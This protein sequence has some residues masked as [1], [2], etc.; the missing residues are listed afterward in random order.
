MALSCRGFNDWNEL[1]AMRFDGYTTP[2][3]PKSPVVVP[4]TL[5]ADMKQMLV[6][7]RFA[8]I[9][10]LGMDGGA[11]IRAHRSVLFSRCPKLEQRLGEAAV[12]DGL[13]CISLSAPASAVQ[14]LLNFLYTDDAAFTLDNVAYLHWLGIQLD[15]PRLIKPSASYVARSLRVHNVLSVFTLST[16]G[17][18]PGL[19]DVCLK[20]ICKNAGAITALPAFADLPASALL[21]VSRAMARD[22]SAKA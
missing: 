18:L 8:D 12:V 11:P 2:K 13:P 16:A 22:L 4:R 15:L 3:P 21:T 1:D 20:F 9:A 6:A 10:L 17:Q 7:A 19:T 5:V 14:E